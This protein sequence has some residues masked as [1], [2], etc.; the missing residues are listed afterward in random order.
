MAP[1]TLLYT[2]NNNNAE[3]KI[4]LFSYKGEFFEETLI[5]NS[6][7]L[8]GLLNSP[9][10]SW[11]TVDGIHKVE[12]IEKIGKNFSIHPLI[13]EDITHN[14]QRPKFEDYDNNLYFVMRIFNYDETSMQLSNEQISFVLGSNYILTF[15]ETPCSVFDNVKDRL[16]KGAQKIRNSNS[17]YLAYALI[18]A[19]V[20]S[21][22]I[23]L[24]KIGTDIEEL[25]D[26]IVVNP[27]KEDIQNLHRLRR[28]L[29][30]MRKSIW[31]LREILNNLL[32]E[33]NGI[34]SKE[35]MVY[36]R[37][38]Y[39]HSIQIIDTIESYRDMVIGMLDVYLSSLSN[40]MN[41][42]MKVLT[43]IS[44]IF[45][46]LTFLAGV[47]GMNFVHFPEIQMTWMYPW[48]FWGFS[49]L[50]IGFMLFLF[51]RKNWL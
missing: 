51:K 25:E 10:I 24:E 31:P 40:K 38:V 48:G 33:V 44:T 7:N 9:H 12:L 32:H 35:T 30:L 34:F 28:E 19:V 11:L 50:L 36:L 18:D 6:D 46:P 39:D 17:D 47:Y 29:I 2:G 41:Q 1:G 21:Y 8:Q 15:C 13:L 27:T 45:I 42:V 5:E 23:I 4:S 16:R 22:F 49:L 43:I 26:G 20:D 14:I 37:D 3:V